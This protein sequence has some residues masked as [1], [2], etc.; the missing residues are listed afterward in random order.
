MSA[1]ALITGATGG[2]GEALC[3]EFARHGH[4]LIVTARDSRKLD[5][6]AARLRRAYGVEVFV[7]ASDLNQPN[8]VRKL[9]QEVRESG[10]HVEYLINNAGFGL[11]GYFFHNRPKTQDAMLRV[12]V[13]APTRLCRMFLPDMLDRG[14]GRIMNVSSTGAF[15]AG[16]YNAVYCASK[17][18]VLSL[19]EAMGEELSGSGI[20][21]SSLC[22]GATRTGFASRAKMETT[23]LFNYGMMSPKDVARAAYRGMMRGEKII[24][25]GCINHML[26]AAAR[27]SPR[28]VATKVSGFIQ[29]QFT[30]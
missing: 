24:V 13:L 25:P 19:S 21:V 20:T 15:M 6:M 9:F 8:A 11:G 30:C 10:A 4:S 23:R 3:R 17:A 5:E 29:R 22:P 18:Y 2:I 1:T 14:T 26:L 12:N 28:C 27:L 16:P 7:I